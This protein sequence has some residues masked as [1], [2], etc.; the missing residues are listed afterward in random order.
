[1]YQAASA[2]QP[3]RQMEGLQPRPGRRSRGADRALANRPREHEPIAQA[4]DILAADLPVECENATS[5]G[6]VLRQAKGGNSAEAP[7]GAPVKVCLERM[8]GIFD[9][10]NR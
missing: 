4:D 8:G 10:R 9:E 5:P 7:Y 2:I 3:L 6:E 1:M